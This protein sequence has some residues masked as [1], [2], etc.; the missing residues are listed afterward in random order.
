MIFTFLN[1]DVIKTSEIALVSRMEE[2]YI[3]YF[4]RK[5]YY[6]I[7]VNNIELERNLIIYIDRADIFKQLVGSLFATVTPAYT[8]N[9][10]EKL[11]E[12][13]RVCYRDM[14]F[15]RKLGMDWQDTDIINFTGLQCFKNFN[16][17][18][19]DLIEKLR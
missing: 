11:D 19:L 6:N 10:V 15:H 16:K 9:G 1:G 12:N 17:E 8:V 2:E 14:V 4:K 18:R 7:I 3:D 5:F 13:I